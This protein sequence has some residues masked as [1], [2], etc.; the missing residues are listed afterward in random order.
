MISTRI[1]P[2]A[3]EEQI[4]ETLKDRGLDEEI[5]ES[6]AAGAYAPEARARPATLAADGARG[7]G[8]RLGGDSDDWGMNCVDGPCGCL[9][10]I[11]RALRSSEQFCS[12]LNLA[13]GT[14][15]SVVGNAELASDEAGQPGGAGV[16]CHGSCKQMPVTTRA[17]LVHAIGSPSTARRGAGG[18]GDRASGAIDLRDSSRAES[19]VEKGMAGFETRNDAN[20][21]FGHTAASG[22]TLQSVPTESKQREVPTVRTV[23]QWVIGTRSM[24]R[25][26]SCPWA[27]RL[28][29][30]LRAMKIQTFGPSAGPVRR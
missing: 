21:S 5:A 19:Y 26:C 3:V 17:S 29:R 27:K 28:E 18:E 4:V 20:A 16:A 14:R 15:I 25:S 2:V 11:C 30:G 22:Q 23:D 8:R 9:V 7:H 24:L 10:E 13:P 6:M 1:N 12:W